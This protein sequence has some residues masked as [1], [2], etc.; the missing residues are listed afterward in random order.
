MHT[1]ITP[2]WWY[3]QRVLWGGGGLFNFGVAL[4]KN[5]DR[6]IIRAVNLPLTSTVMKCQHSS[7]YVWQSLYNKADW[8]LLAPDPAKSSMTTDIKR[9]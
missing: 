4:H 5:Q 8:S 3:V 9:I 7:P 6:N 1:F 2:G